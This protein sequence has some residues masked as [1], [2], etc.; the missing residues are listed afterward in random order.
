MGYTH[1]FIFH[2]SKR[3]ETEQNEK[4]YQ[5]AMLDCAKV[6]RYYSETF[7]GLAGYT[8]HSKPYQYGGIEVN[9]SNRVGACEPLVF[10]EHLKENE[11][12]NFCKT[13]RHSY[14]TV[15]TACLIILKHRLG[16]LIEVK[17]DGYVSDWADGLNLARLVL[18]LK[19]IEVPQTISEKQRTA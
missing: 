5:K 15:V 12:F 6:I 3:G 19:T 7:G 14:D 9:G 11:G 2:A 4:R 8:A 17:S 1:C 18:G 13:N 16:D 10:R